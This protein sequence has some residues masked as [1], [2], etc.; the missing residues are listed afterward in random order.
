MRYQIVSDSSSNVFH[1]E[2]V[3]YTTVPMKIIMGEKEFID[4]ENLN[5]RGM[6]DDLR[7]YKGKSGSSCANAQEWLEAFGDADMVFGVTISRNLSGSYNAA[8]AAAREYVEEHPGA[9]VHIFD[10]LS[11]GPE[12]AMVVDKIAGL[13][14]QGLSFE[15]IVAGVREY[16]NHCHTLFCLESMNNLARNGR[17]NPAVAKLPPWLMEQLADTLAES[18]MTVTEAHTFG[19]DNICD[20]CG[21]EGSATPAPEYSITYT[22]ASVSTAGDIGLNFYATMSED[23]MADEDAYM[24]FTVAGEE[25]IVPITDALVTTASNGPKTYRF[26]AKVSAR[27]MADN[28]SAQ[29][30]ASDGT[31][32]GDPKVYSVKAYCEKAIPTY[33]SYASYA[34]LVN[35]LKA[36]LNYGAYSQIKFG[37]NTDNLANAGVETD[38]L[39]NITAADLASFAHGKEG[40]EDGITIQSVSLLLESTTT[41]RFY[42]KLTGTRSIDEF[43]FDVDGEVV[44][45]V[46]YSGNTYYVDKVGVSARNLDENSYVTVGGLRVWYNGMSYVRQILTSS[47]DAAL[48]NACKALYA[49]SEAAN[50]YFT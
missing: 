38:A 35:L 13:V 25:Q 11:A 46:H 21:H 8:E 16:Q 9:K 31:K 29:M 24:V 48:I 1:L 36:M 3:S 49:Y 15:E 44:E 26:S 45:P 17:V 12:M 6:V 14:N 27:Q 33:S 20:I 34:N 42:F 23:L 43:T 30:Y 41:I 10:S 40:S 5:V 19:E 50:A 2:G 18:G 7:A 28:V 22:Q 4:N 37:Y 32:V 47:S 39:P